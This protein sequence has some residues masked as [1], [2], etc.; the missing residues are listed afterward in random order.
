MALAKTPTT[1]LSN[2]TVSAAGTQTSTSSLDLSSAISLAIG[3]TMTFNASATSGARIE[4]FADPTGAN[5]SFSVGSY[6]DLIDSW[7]IPVDAG[8]TVNGAV[9]LNHSAKYVK[10]RLKNLDAG[11]TITAAYLYGIVQT[12]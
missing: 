6:D 9:Q 11:Y 3:F 12:A 7:D 8:H 1:L 10:V 4:V 2:V 5:T